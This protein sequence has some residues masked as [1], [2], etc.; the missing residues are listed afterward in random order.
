MRNSL[1]LQVPRPVFPANAPRAT[2]APW[3][4]RLKPASERTPRPPLTDR[5]LEC[6]RWISLGKSSTD[7]GV[8][9]RI[10][11]RTVDYHVI[12]ICERLGVRTRMQA[13]ALAIQRGW[14]SAG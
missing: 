5:Q 14:L 2:T 7:I 8:I 9:L 1:A 4:A 6:L 12:A 3:S 11:G 10:S 13:V